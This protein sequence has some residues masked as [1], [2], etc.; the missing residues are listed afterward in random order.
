MKK[1]IARRIK[2]ILAE[3]GETQQE[4][5]EALGFK[6]RQSVIRRLNGSTLTS[7]KDIK[8]ICK[9]LKATKEELGF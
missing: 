7:E 4:F 1:M 9:H 3:K 8:K 2:K 6:S 5:A